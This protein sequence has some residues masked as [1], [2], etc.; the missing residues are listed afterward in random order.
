MEILLAAGADI[1]VRDTNGRSPL[2]QADDAAI[3]A[4]LRDHGAQ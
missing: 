1:N 3:A 2:D 4:I